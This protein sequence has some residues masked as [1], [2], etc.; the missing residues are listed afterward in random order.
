M[1]RVWHDSKT[2]DIF[3]AINYSALYPRN[4]G[5]RGPS[6]DTYRISRSLAGFRL[7]VTE[8]FILSPLSQR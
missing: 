7:T 1:L 4:S 2:L 8:S 5:I 3:R 6:F